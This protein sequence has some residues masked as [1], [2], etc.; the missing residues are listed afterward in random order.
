MRYIYII[1]YHLIGFDS[2]LMEEKQEAENS[3][4]NCDLRHGGDAVVSLID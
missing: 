2:K 4:S 1:G 3:R